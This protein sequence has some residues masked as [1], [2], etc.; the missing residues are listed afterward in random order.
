MVGV[1]VSKNQ[2]TLVLSLLPLGDVK[3]Y[4]DTAR[5]TRL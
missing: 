4:R 2:Y 1:E 5:Y 3:L